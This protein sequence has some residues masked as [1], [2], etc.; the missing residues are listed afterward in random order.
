M[1]TESRPVSSRPVHVNRGERSDGTGALIAL[2]AGVALVVLAALPNPLFQLDRFT[3]VKELVLVAAALAATLLCIGSARKL[4]VFTVDLAIAGFLALSVLSALLAS[5]GW[6]ATRAVGVSLAGAGLFWSARTVARAGHGRRLLAG[7][8][9]SVVLGAATGLIQAYG[10]ITTDLASAT[11]APGGT[12]G[13]RNFMAHLIAIGLPVLIL[14][15]VQAQRRRSFGL[16][17]VGV[18]IVT[19]ALVLSRSRAAW[20]G[21][22]VAGTFLAVEG[23]WIGRLWADQR[24]RSRTL[25]LG[26]L[27]LGG[28]LLAIVLPNRL[29]WRSDSPYL[30]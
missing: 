5:N 17:A 3:F 6:L 9:A 29:N 16:G 26:A 30:D 20:L 11:R 21:A 15:T 1:Q 28:L 12:F 7:L 8:A 4:R 2:Q 13:N 25:T 22:A 18:T 19:A 27:A 14:V 23:L 10:L 24:L